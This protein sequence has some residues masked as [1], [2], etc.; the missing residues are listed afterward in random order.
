MW[1]TKPGALTYVAVRYP[2]GRGGGRVKVEDEVIGA[3]SF[4]RQGEGMKKAARQHGVVGMVVNYAMR[5]WMRVWRSD[6]VMPLRS[7]KL[8]D[9]AEKNAAQRTVEKF[10][11]MEKKYWERPELKER[12][13]VGAIC[14]ADEWRGR[15]VGKALMA[16]ATKRCADERVPL[17]LSATEDGV[18]LYRKMWFE[19]LDEIALPGGGKD[20]HYEIM[21]W[22]PR[23]R[24]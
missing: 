24:N 5:V 7:K 3:M 6:W 10:E 2:Q 22:D 20:S 8:A 21:V 16:V 13:Y 4:S 17:T 9:E 23:K 11:A 19:K 15:G 1:M 18:H 12:Y 14:V